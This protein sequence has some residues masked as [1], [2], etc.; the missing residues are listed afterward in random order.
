MFN[1]D[2]RDHM[3]ALSRLGAVNLC[4]CG[5]H[6]RG[7]CPRCPP[8]KSAADKIATRCQV[9]GG[10]ASKYGSGPIIHRVRCTPTEAPK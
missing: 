2:Q 10:E 9:C 4:W 1:S 8:E 3:D 6:P 7:K 5:W